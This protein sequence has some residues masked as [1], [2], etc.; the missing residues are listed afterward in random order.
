[1]K[2]IFVF[3]FI[4]ALA[5]IAGCNGKINT[6]KKHSDLDHPIAIRGRNITPDSIEPPATFLLPQPTVYSAYKTG[7]YPVEKERVKNFTPR[8]IPVP[9]PQVIKPGEGDLAAPVV[10]KAVPQTG[11][12][13]L[14]EIATIKDP[15]SLEKNPFAFMSYSKIQGLSHDEI[16]GFYQD[17]QGY[18]WIA[19][20]GG[21]LMRFDGHNLAYYNSTAIGEITSI[22]QI[23]GDAA[24]NIWLATFRGLFKINENQTTYYNAE[25]GGLLKAGV[26]SID[27]DKNGHLWIAYTDGGISRFDG[28]YFYHYEKDQGLN[29]GRGQVVR[30][31]NDGNIWTTSFT[32]D[33]YNYRDGVFYLYE[34]PCEKLDNTLNFILNFDQSNNL[35]LT[36]FGEGIMK[37]NG[38][39]FEVYLAKDGFPSTHVSNLTADSKGRLWFSTWGQ[40]ILISENDQFRI[41]GK[42][43]GLAT[44]LIN[45]I[46]EDRGGNLWIGGSGGMLRYFGDIFRHYTSKK[47]FD[48]QLTSLAITTDGTIWLASTEGGI[49]NFNGKAFQQYS[50][51]GLP[52]QSMGALVADSQ[53]NLWLNIYNKGIFRF[54]GNKF[55]HYSFDHIPTPQFIY[56]GLEDPKGNLWLLLNK[57]LLKIN[58]EKVTYYSSK[59]GLPDVEFIAITAD[60]HSNIWIATEGAGLI[61]FSDSSI[62]LFTKEDGLLSNSFLSIYADPEGHIWCGTDEG[63]S[64][65]N[66]NRFMNFIQKDGLT[67]NYIFSIMKDHMGN[68]IFGG[69]FGLNIM[70]EEYVKIATSHN[71]PYFSDQTLFIKYT[72]E[73]GFLGIG[74][75]IGNIARDNDKIWIGTNNRLTAFYPQEAFNDTLKPETDIFQIEVFNELVDWQLVQNNQDTTL[76]FSNG[77][78][79]RNFSFKGLTPMHKLPLNLSLAHNNNFITFI[80]TGITP[81]SIGKVRYSYKLEGFDQKWN[82]LSHENKAHYGNLPPGDYVFK[83]KSVNRLGIWSDE[84]QYSFRIRKAWWNTWFARFVYVVAVVFI[85]SSYIKARERS[86]I[87]ENKL[88]DN[89]VELARKTIEIKQNIIANVSH[90]LRTPLTGIIGLSEILAKTPLNERQKE[91]VLTLRQTGNNLRE[92]INQILDYSK[93]RSGEITL[94]NVTFSLPDLFT[95]AEKVF[96]S[97]HQKED[98]AITTFIHPDVPKMLY[99]DRGRIN[100]ILHNLLY[101]AIK[102]THEGS[103]NLEASVEKVF[104]VNLNG[105]QEVQIKISVRDTGVGISKEAQ[106]K[107]FVPF[108]QIENNDIR[109]TDSTGLGLAIS[110]KLS[111]LL[112]GRIGVESKVG[113]GSLFWFTFRVMKV[114]EFDMDSDDRSRQDS[115]NH[116][117]KSILLVEDKKVN[118]LVIK[119]MLE[120]M[121]HRVEVACNGKEALDAFTEGEYDV[122][123]MDIQ[124]PIMDGIT[125]T[126][127]LKTQYNVLPPIVGLSANAFDGD[128]EKYMGL[129]MDEYITKPVTEESLR[130]ILEKTCIVKT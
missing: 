93:I 14:P 107:L 19:T 85:L 108:S 61:K 9:K 90:E 105:E 6:E 72:Y 2:N 129:G 101:N 106:K 91:Y 45:E 25:E 47:E 52:Y 56:G 69:R 94:K 51:E 73:D 95:H 1:M 118:Q 83:V 27:F 65:Y 127:E 80:F 121:G 35:W 42:E 100:Q 64:M 26:L 36:G 77:V 22:F 32:S 84:A 78:K 11:P 30:A 119:L 37:F 66:G 12:T 96:D 113:E 41:L 59:Q 110:K 126:R 102:F 116:I 48:Q 20:Y 39:Q 58:G 82:R 4:S 44:E 89:E 17:K 79:L 125:A 49:M 8:I 33:L 60:A 112:K 55:Y 124:M 15:F 7:N 86:L 16:M 31:D 38:S 29:S 128:R 53:D 115:E 57:S 130:Q 3:L 63:I 104:P 117:P 92:I 62:T 109:N 103:I 18:M 88:L 23:M 50:V 28:E 114:K 68:M 67:D 87:L 98:V 70:P 120:S 81:A 74:C 21:G 76:I 111:E 40:G 123:L 71:H 5:V 10:K 43:E 46:Y 34:L 24:G 75:N 13:P 99:G 122:I 54:N 97:L